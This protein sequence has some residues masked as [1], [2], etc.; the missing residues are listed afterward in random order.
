M[1]ILIFN[2]K[3]KVVLKLF[4][5]SVI[6]L[7]LVAGIP[8]RK[9]INLEEFCGNENMVYNTVLRSADEQLKGTKRFPCETLPYLERY[10]LMDSQKQN[11]N[12]PVKKIGEGAV[13][14]VA[15][16]GPYF[17]YLRRILH[18]IKQVFGKDQKVIGYD[19][20]GISENSAMEVLSEFNTVFYGD[21]SL[22]FVQ[23]EPL[24]K[25]LQYIE[26]GVIS[27]FQMPSETSY[28][29]KFATLKGFYRYIPDYTYSLFPT[30]SHTEEEASFI[31]AQRS[32]YT[33][34][35]L[36]WAVSCAVTKDCINI[37]P[38]ST[39]NC[40]QWT[41]NPV[42]LK[43]P[44]GYHKCHLYDQTTLNL[45]N[46]NLEHEIL[47]KASPNSKLI[48]RYDK[49]HPRYWLQSYFYVDK[50]KTLARSTDFIGTVKC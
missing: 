46:G 16:N 3:I 15:A 39:I 45:L 18:S 5:Y 14:V 32:E 17:P 7:T 43:T 47:V 35:L 30:T 24:N 22:N 13:F 36:K 1:A 28:S 41:Y 38:P 37:I 34:R 26:Q 44:L 49:R 48:S 31:I 20:G 10:G 6:H 4:I 12:A 33:R 27:P 42:I 23:K 25:F 40:A 11:W 8:P 9:A 21:T 29:S 19:L 50:C 2:Q